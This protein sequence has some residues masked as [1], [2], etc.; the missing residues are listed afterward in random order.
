MRIRKLQHTCE[1]YQEPQYEYP[2]LMHRLKCIY[3]KQYTKKH[4]QYQIPLCALNVTS[5]GEPQVF[6]TSIVKRHQDA[7]LSFGNFLIQLANQLVEDAIVILKGIMPRERHS[8]I[9]YTVK[10]IGQQ[11]CR[12]QNASN[13]V[14]RESV[15][16]LRQAYSN[17]IVALLLDLDYYQK[18]N[19]QQKVRNSKLTMKLSRSMQR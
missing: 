4:T 9:W 10:E 16:R 18:I 15:F 19:S 5:N 8:S 12:V 6:R 3:Q 14:E 11:S 1:W 7:A 2:R 17:N 13:G